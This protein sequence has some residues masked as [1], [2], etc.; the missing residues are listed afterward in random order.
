LRN[1]GSIFDLYF[2]VGVRF[3]LGVST[4]APLSSELETS[5]VSYYATKS[6]DLQV[7][8]RAA[9]TSDPKPNFLNIRAHYH[10]HVVLD[11][12]RLV[13]SHSQTHAPHAIVQMNLGGIQYVGQVFNIISHKQPGAAEFEFLLEVWWFKRASDID[14]SPW[15]P[16]CGTFFVLSGQSLTKHAASPELK[17][18]FWKHNTF[19]NSNLAGPP[20]LVPVHSIQSQASRL[21]IKINEPHPD[22]YDSDADESDILPLEHRLVWMSVGLSLVCSRHNIQHYADVYPLR[23]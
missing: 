6:P 1:Q 4:F 5:L 18:F 13:P 17:V 10:D 21:T 15:D 14:T 2:A 11:G 23:M 7:L 16:L 3:L 19:L 20:R 12:R 9:E 8:H 22:G